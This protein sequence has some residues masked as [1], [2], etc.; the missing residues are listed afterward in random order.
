MSTERLVQ[1][2]KMLETHQDDPFLHYAAALEFEKLKNFEEAKLILSELLKKQPNY[3]PTYYRL[4]QI[5]EEL[6]ENDEAIQVYKLGKK[7]AEETKDLKA[8]GELAEALMLL[9]VFDE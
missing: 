2:Q 7:L 4:G 9:D 5:L 1:I 3:L 6:H 8:A